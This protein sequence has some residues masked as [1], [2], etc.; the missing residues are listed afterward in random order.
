MSKIQRTVFQVVIMDKETG[1]CGPYTSL[2]P[3]RMW[4]TFKDEKGREYKVVKIE[5]LTTYYE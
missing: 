4:D 2:Q 5:E 3:L 1:W